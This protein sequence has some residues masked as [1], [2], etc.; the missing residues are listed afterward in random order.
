MTAPSTVDAAAAWAAR[1]PGP[2]LGA[3]AAAAWRE[4]AAEGDAAGYTSPTP[5]FVGKEFDEHHRWHM[6]AGTPGGHGG[7]F[8]T[9]GA[10]AGAV[11]DAVRDTA[12]PSGGGGHKAKT[13]PE[14][15]E[16]GRVIFDRQP[17]GRIWSDTHI[18]AFDS[19]DI[20]VSQDVPH[21]R[22][23]DQPEPEWLDRE[24]LGFLDVDSAGR[25]ADMI[26]PLARGFADHEPPDEDDEMDEGYD[27]AHLV[28]WDTA[29]DNTVFAG[30]NDQGEFLIGWLK[31]GVE[32]PDSFD[33]STRDRYD[34]WSVEDWS[35]ADNF[36]DALEEAAGDMQDMD[37]EAEQEDSTLLGEDQELARY[38]DYSFSIN[39]ADGDPVYWFRTPTAMQIDLKYL[40]QMQAE[41]FDQPGGKPATR[42]YAMVRYTRDADGAITMSDLMYKPPVEYVIEPG[43]LGDLI[44]TMDVALD[45]AEHDG[46]RRFLDAGHMRNA[47]KAVVPDLVKVGPKGYIHGWIYVGPPKVGDLVHHPEHGKGRVT[48]HSKATVGVQFDS[49][50]YHAFGHAPETPDPDEHFITRPG[51]KPKAPPKPKLGPRATKTPAQ[52]RA[53]ALDMAGRW[54]GNPY[55]RISPIERLTARDWKA[56]TDDERRKVIDSVQRL[57]DRAVRNGAEREG[58]EADLL[59][60]AQTILDKYG[61]DDA[62]ERRTAAI[63]DLRTRARAVRRMGNARAAYAPGSEY[64]ERGLRDLAEADRL[65]AEADALET[66]AVVAPPPPKTPRAAKPKQYEPAGTVRAEGYSSGAG[67]RLRVVADG[68]GGYVGQR[69]HRGSN[70]WQDDPAMG[71]GNTVRDLTSRFPRGQWRRIA[72]PKAEPAAPRPMPR[73]AKVQPGDRVEWTDRDGTTVQGTVGRDRRTYVDWDSGR[74]EYVNAAKL[75]QQGIRRIG[76]GD[77]EYTSHMRARAE[78]EPQDTPA[79]LPTRQTDEQILA[80]A[81]TELRQLEQARR[82]APIGDDN[83]TSTNRANAR[84]AG[85]A[86]RLTAAQPRPSDPIEH[87]N[88]VAAHADAVRDVA[89]ALSTLDELTHNG[90]STRAVEHR[91]QIVG[92]SMRPEVVEELTQAGASGDPT[93]VTAA[94]D[95]VA[96]AHGLTRIGAP[97]GGYE[98]LN[99]QTHEM[100]GGRSAPPN[101]TFVRVVRPGFYA[102]IDGRRVVL[103]RS[104]VDVATPEEIAAARGV[105]SAGVRTVERFEQQRAVQRE[106]NAAVGDEHVTDVR[107]SAENRILRLAEQPGMPPHIYTAAN[108]I[109]QR[110]AGVPSTPPPVATAPAEPAPA[111]PIPPAPAGNL[112]PGAL[113]AGTWLGGQAQGFRTGSLPHTVLQ[114]VADDLLQGRTTP[115]Q[116]AQRL[117]T[118]R[119]ITL[120]GIGE[121]LRTDMERSAEFARARAHARGE[122]APPDEPQIR[123]GRGRMGRTELEATARAVHGDLNF[124]SPDRAQQ[125]LRDQPV[126]V[127]REIARLHGLVGMLGGRDAVARMKK[128]EL[129]AQMGGWFGS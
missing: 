59:A 18:T 50:N 83:I 62:E 98:P 105:S 64:H 42:E 21:Y 111:N 70:E 125:I 117:R 25:V 5:G 100:L 94:L 81:Q 85:A 97:A 110:R 9:A 1:E 103:S 86:A 124:S 126:A 22:P 72:P 38:K 82:T 53:D 8:G 129:L 20:I 48:R 104:V 91:L 57:K 89:T 65:D 90:A 43:Q 13:L 121:Q 10:V 3:L 39:D 123:V 69:M 116:A 54:S 52:R 99:P 31:D 77:D 76:D 120:R 109:R 6:P 114:Q 24:E 92:R 101:G 49:G 28:D 12:A 68:K 127:I 11:V 35:D 33:E 93:Q 115:E 119:D 74:R 106:I 108:D 37:D 128:P 96:A 34:E 71:T 102:D 95:R 73:G 118:D 23:A 27:P 14:F 2:A 55:L 75:N 32:P 60:A 107:R 41:G 122:P 58:H 112:P 15:L 19:G 29:N 4:W 47:N 79:A 61:P 87:G 17:F 67:V 36:A 45:G 80:T 46:R 26:R 51:G 30:Y 88:W 113:T 16:T 66:P 78:F 84:A 56:F 40:R 7:E 44:E 63:H